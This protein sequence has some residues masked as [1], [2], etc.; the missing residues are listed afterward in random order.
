[1]GKY[2]QYDQKKLEEIVR[3]LKKKENKI[4]LT[5][6][7]FD[8][9]TPGHISYLKKIKKNYKGIL[10]VN[11]AN[12]KRVKYRKGDKRPINS[13]YTRAVVLSNSEVVDY[14]TIHPE[15]NSS[16]AFQLASIIKP[17]ILVQ[18]RPWTKE[19]RKELESILKENMPKL[20]RLEETQYKKRGHTTDI[21]AMISERHEKPEKSYNNVK[22][23]ISSLL[24]IKRNYEFSFDELATFLLK[25]KSKE[26]R[27][28]FLKPLNE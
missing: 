26:Y 9:L 12:D 1:M 20:I 6:G 16:P 17:D 5:S 21:V 28:L 18:S 7:C 23:L 15:I 19:L 24:K 8:I 4:L 25:I 3:E 10:F 27:N 22:F 13:S 2:I 11:V 14:V